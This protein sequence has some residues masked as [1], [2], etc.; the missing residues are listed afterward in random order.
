MSEPFFWIFFATI[1]LL[2]VPIWVNIHAHFDVL[3]RKIWF[4]IR[5]FHVIKLLGGYI[6]LT[7][8]GFAIH[9]SKKK[10][11]IF[12]YTQLFTMRK[13]FEIT[14]GF[15][16]LRLRFTI[17]TNGAERMYGVA[18]ATGLRIIGDVLYPILQTKYPLLS[19]K[20]YILL[21]D[22]KIF[23]ISMEMVTA[24]N[25]VILIIAIIKKIL[26]GILQ[27]IRERKSTALWKK[28]QNN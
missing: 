2:I 15:Q 28:R 21:S 10:A 27:W 14:N 4:S 13:Q 26:E 1:V 18:I 25:F 20:N 23:T 9:V 8:E 24:F 7:N 6:L 3:E 11:L 5:L 12:P 17:E 16:L 19:A 22:K